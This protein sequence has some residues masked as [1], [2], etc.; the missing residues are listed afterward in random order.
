MI[1][2]FNPKDLAS[3]ER[4]IDTL[5]DKKLEQEIL[6]ILSPMETTRR[7]IEEWKRIDGEKEEAKIRKEEEKKK[8]KR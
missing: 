3:V 2:K 6:E 8:T 1:S 4:T 7:K 5:M